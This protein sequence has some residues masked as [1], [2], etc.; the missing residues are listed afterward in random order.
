MALETDVIEKVVSES[1]KIKIQV[2][3]EDELERGERKKLNFGHTFGH[4]IEKTTGLS[5][6]EAISA[7]M[8]IANRY[9]VKKGLLKEK[10]SVRLENL[11]KK[12]NIPVDLDMNKELIY[13][14]IKKDKK[15]KFRMY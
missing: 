13:E 10:D 5:H 9:A 14:A 11:M 6:G 8:I 2:V 12:F 7:G 4:A 15:K 3:E 1:I